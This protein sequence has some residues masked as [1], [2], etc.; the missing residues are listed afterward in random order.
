MESL[1]NMERSDRDRK[2]AFRLERMVELCR[3]FDDPQ[4]CCPVIHLA[5]S[6]GKGSTGAFLS[7]ILAARG[8]KVGLYT[9]PHL[10]DYRERIQIIEPKGKGRFAKEGFLL[11]SMNHIRQ[12][13]NRAELTGGYPT[14]FE[15]L[16]LL[17][18]LIFREEGCD[19][20]VLETGLGG[21]LD[22]TNVCRPVLTLITPIEREHCEFLGETLEEIAA[23]KG[24]IIKEGIPLVCASQKG[25]VLTVLEGKAKERNAPFSCLSS[26]LK[27][28][29][30]SYGDGGIMKI[31]YEWA[32]GLNYPA[33]AESSLI[34]PVQAENAA[35]AVAAL[36]ILDPDLPHEVIKAGLRRAVLPGRSQILSTD[37]LIMLDGAHTPRSTEAIRDA[38]LELTAGLSPRVLIF[39]CALDK[40]AR[41]MGEILAGSFDKVIISRPGTFKKSDPPGTAGIFREFAPCDLM[42][43]P[44]EAVQAALGEISSGGALLVTGSFYLAGE[45]F[46]VLS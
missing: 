3:F 27:D 28:Y 10:I 36:G 45:V 13:L 44:S 19:F 6:K 29:S 39:G 12:K 2:R 14:T 32:E 9:S 26:L 18:F 37:P 4:E 23:E 38:F 43:E 8:E 34:G 15:L 25:S 40:D 11:S 35:L 24:G 22:A 1:S 5:G 41:A 20:V 30:V 21:R 31:R 46:H 33:E 16:T 17:A 42:E 7:H